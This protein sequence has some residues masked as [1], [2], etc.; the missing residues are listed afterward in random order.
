MA[1]CLVTSGEA[2]IDSMPPDEC[3]PLREAEQRRSAAAVGVSEVE[4]LGFSDG[5]V[6]Y[7]LPLRRAMARAIRRHRPEVLVTINHHDTWG[8][9]WRNH[10]DHIAVGHALIDASRDAANRWV[11]QEDGERWDGVRMLC[12][13]GSHHA[14]HAVDVTGAEERGVASL[15]EHR[16]YLDALDGPEPA[17]RTL[18]ESMAGTGRDFGT[19]S[20][21]SFEVIPL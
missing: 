6:E 9:R 16:T 10:A 4:F 21:V 14:T 12:V 8:G 15:L 20:A 11:F 17:V 13:S 18:R 7:G 2:G 1:Y 19:T 5:L 3:R